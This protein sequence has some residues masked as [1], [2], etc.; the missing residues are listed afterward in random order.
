MF[1][2]ESIFLLVRDI[3]AE[4]SDLDMLRDKISMDCYSACLNTKSLLLPFLPRT[5]TVSVS[6]N[7]NAYID[8]VESLLS[9]SAKLKVLEC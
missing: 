2:N 1:K 7:H 9:G 3:I 6:L 8:K 5:K 4:N